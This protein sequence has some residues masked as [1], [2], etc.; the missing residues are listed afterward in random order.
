ML[1]N[2]ANVAELFRGF[3]VI[4]MQAYH[5]AGAPIWEAE[6]LAMGVTS[7]GESESYDW[8]GAMPTLRELIG[9]IQIRN[10]SANTW[11]IINREFE[12]TIGIK[13]RDIERDRFGLYNPVLQ[14]M[15]DNARRYPDRMLAKLLTDGFTNKDYT[16]KNFFDAN[17][18]GTPGTKFPFTNF[19]TKK[20][21][22]DNFAAARQNILE[23]RAANGEP[24]DLGADLLLLVTP[25]NEGLSKQILQSDFVMQTAQAAGTGGAAGQVSIAGAGV[26]NVNKGTARLKVWPL[27]SAYNS[28]AWFLLETGM[29]LKPLIVQT[30]LPPEVVGVTNINDSHVVLKKEF[31]YQAYTRLGAGYGMPELIYGSSGADPA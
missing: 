3:R 16:G 28:D 26:T 18:A 19:T 14:T 22:A 29:P 30:E 1:V 10:L 13:R 12:N 8:L 4:F 5:G 17:K 11:R 25:K 21:S 15:G 27:L 20:L 23:R 7:N 9:D 6:R 24:M 2:A 31:L